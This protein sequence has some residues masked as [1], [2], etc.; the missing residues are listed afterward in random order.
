MADR[1]YQQRFHGLFD[2]VAELNRMREFWRAGVDPPRESRTHATAWI[3]TMDIFARGEDLVIRCELAGIG[4]D[5]V[6]ISLDH[7]VLTISGE[8]SGAPE[9]EGT[10]YYVRERHYG[11]FRRRIDLPEGTDSSRVTASLEDGLLEITVEGGAV[12]APEPERIDIK[13]VGGDR[14]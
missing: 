12:A 9:E 2:T 10:T 14:R 8:R 5:D 7:G 3:P 1:P 11:E 13:T 6:S 4:S